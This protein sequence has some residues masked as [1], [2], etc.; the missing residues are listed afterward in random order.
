M[1]H[2]SPKT[3]IL[4]LGKSGVGKSSLLNYLFDAPISEVGHGVPTTKIGIHTNPPFLHNDIE[5]CVYDSWG[6]EPATADKWKEIVEEEV[7]KNNAESL[8]DW[9]HTVVYCV[10]AERARIEDFEINDVLQPLIDGG[11]K[12]LFALTKCALN[13]ANTKST[14]A[15]LREKF[16]DHE[17]VAVES[18]AAK[19]YGR[20]TCQAGREELLQKFVVNFFHNI[21]YKSIIHYKT[22]TIKALNSE[23]TSAVM[24]FFD[25][26]A[27]YLGVFT[28]YGEE[29]KT[30]I[31]AFAEQQAKSIIALQLDIL[32]KNIADAQHIASQVNKVLEPKSFALMDNFK[33]LSLDLA[34]WNNEISDYVSSVISCIFLPFCIFTKKQL[35]REK[36]KSGCQPCIDKCEE[37][38]K[39]QCNEILKSFGLSAPKEPEIKDLIAKDDLYEIYKKISRN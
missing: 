2:S 8:K 26:E 13:P 4:I 33:M 6:M 20:T 18:V 19:L 24:D 38:I 15:V 1:T 12:I 22:S 36:I 5:F 7:Q 9:F 10:D 37:E 21:L 29:F 28:H 39:K 32:L 35:Y 34:N 30:K 27:G 16:P 17:C 11:N 23:F 3:N 14:E 31:S 25:N